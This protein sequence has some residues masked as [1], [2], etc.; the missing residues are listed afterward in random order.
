MP[1]LFGVYLVILRSLDWCRF[2]GLMYFNLKCKYFHLGLVIYPGISTT[3]SI[4][5][6]NIEEVADEH[7]NQ[8]NKYSVEHNYNAF[9]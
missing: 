6:H 4:W 3:F 1:F 2:Y 9:L 5:L 7:K 8:I